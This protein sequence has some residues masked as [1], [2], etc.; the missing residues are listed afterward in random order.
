MQ[1][2]ATKQTNTSKAIMQA[3]AD[4]ARVALQAMAVAWAENSTRHEVT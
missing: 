3:A 2:M 4:A 1:K